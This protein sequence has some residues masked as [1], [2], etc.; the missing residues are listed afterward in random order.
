[1]S[2]YSGTCRTL[3]ES[4]F[5]VNNEFY[6]VSF[7]KRSE[8]T[9]IDFDFDNDNKFQDFVVNDE[10]YVLLTF[11]FI[12][13]DGSGDLTT[14][15]HPVNQPGSSSANGCT[16]CTT[17][18]DGWGWTESQVLWL[19]LEDDES[20]RDINYGSAGSQ[21]IEIHFKDT[22][23]W[24]E[25]SCTNTIASDFS[26]GMG[27]LRSIELCQGI[28]PTITG[29]SPGN[30]ALSHMPAAVPLSAVEGENVHYT[31]ITRQTKTLRRVT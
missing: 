22:S 20:G 12:N 3:P 31:A 11:S 29:Y 15:S 4:T 14:V 16:D 21:Y 24:L 6:D 26:S 9:R 23:M 8:K 30:V 7:P 27:C 25:D 1:M 19:E 10:T 17:S 5:N 18:Q 28:S 2:G 13:F